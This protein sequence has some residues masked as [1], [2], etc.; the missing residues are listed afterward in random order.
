MHRLG[1]M[2]A[3]TADYL[4]LTGDS[5]WSAQQDCR[6]HAPK[7]VYQR[8]IR[9]TEDAGTVCT[10]QFLVTTG[11]NERAAVDGFV[12]HAQALVIEQHAS[13]KFQLFSGKRSRSSIL[14]STRMRRAQAAQT[15]LQLLLNS[16]LKP[17]TEPS[18]RMAALPVGPAQYPPALFNILL[19]FQ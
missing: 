17:A 18:A 13:N 16:G 8:L 1:I 19:Q 3:W 9:F 5:T 7:I 10:L 6:K 11:L 4:K 12:G 14:E 2:D 15:R